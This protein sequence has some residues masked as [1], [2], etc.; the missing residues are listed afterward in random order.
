[1]LA[2]SEEVAFAKPI[3]DGGSIVF[4]SNTVNLTPHYGAQIDNTSINL[5]SSEG[6]TLLHV[7]ICRVENAIVFN[8]NPSGKGWG[9]EE[10]IPLQGVFERTDATIT[11]HLHRETWVIL[12]DGTPIKAYNQRIQKPATGASYRGNDKDALVF[13]D[14]LLITV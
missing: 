10:R 11:I 1:L 8:S 9:Q 3:S 6:D 4:Y 13:A 14:P 5:L 7:S 2:F 12:A